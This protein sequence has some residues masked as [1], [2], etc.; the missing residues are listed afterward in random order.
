MDTRVRPLY[1]AI[2]VQGYIVDELHDLQSLLQQLLGP[3]FYKARAPWHCTLDHLPQGVDPE[4]VIVA[5]RHAACQ[6]VPIPVVELAT[7]ITWWHSIRKTPLVLEVAS[8]KE[9]LTVM[10]AIVR[11]MLLREGLQPDGDRPYKAHVTL[12]YV[13]QPIPN[14]PALMRS[15][16]VPVLHFAVK[17]CKVYCIANEPE[18]TLG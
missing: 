8:Y 4:K 1:I 18:F 13:T 2:P 10:A 12:G 15:I 16:Q 7:H 9:E 5:A 3:S 11:Q 14:L 17:Y 6:M